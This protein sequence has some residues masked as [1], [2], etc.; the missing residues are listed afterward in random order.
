MKV[1]LSQTALLAAIVVLAATAAAAATEQAPVSSLLYDLEYDENQRLDGYYLV[2]EPSPTCASAGLETSFAH[3]RY[4]ARPAAGNALLKLFSNNKDDDDDPSACRAVCLARGVDRDLV[5]A[6]MPH[7]RYAGNAAGFDDFFRTSCSQVESCLMNYY[8]QQEPLQIYW[9]HPVTAEKKP[10]FKIHHGEQKTKCFSTFLGHEFVAETAKGQEVGRVTIE[11][12]TVMAFGES[13]PCDDPN[14][15]K[16][17][18]REIVSTLKSEWIRHERIKRTFSPLGF[19]KGRLPDD[20]FAYLGA[21]YYNNRHNKV[22]EEWKGKGVFVNWWET[23]GTY[24]RS[25]S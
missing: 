1:L 2:Y 12:S 19:D 23:N 21:F 4:Q 25:D 5:S 10:H 3:N 17:V 11:F 7:M 8:D 24:S 15:H 18:E 20:V 13:P 9:I 6:V 16:N 22:L 14:K